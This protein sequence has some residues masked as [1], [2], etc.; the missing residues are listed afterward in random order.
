MFCEE[1]IVVEIGTGLGARA[2]GQA[3]DL[4]ELLDHLILARIEAGTVD[5]V[6]VEMRLTLQVIEARVACACRA[7][8]IRIDLLEIFD[9]CVD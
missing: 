7:R 1:G 9:H 3:L 8:Q 2:R 4:R 5:G 6:A